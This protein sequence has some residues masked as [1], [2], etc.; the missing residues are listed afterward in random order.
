M[1]IWLQIRGRILHLINSGKLKEGDRLP[2]M[3]Q[4]SIELK[5]NHNTVNKVY[6]DLQKDG[7]V[8]FRRGVGL[9]VSDL[10]LI[11]SDSMNDNCRSLAEE[12]VERCIADGMTGEEIVD[13]VSDVVCRKC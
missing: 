11:T 12:F 1:P 5:V 6:Q 8:S 2:S 13:L 10:S 3:R 9:F 4:L 7:F